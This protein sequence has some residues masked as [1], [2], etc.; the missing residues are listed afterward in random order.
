MVVGFQVGG[1]TKYSLVGVRIVASHPDFI[2]VITT[3]KRNLNLNPDDPKSPVIVE[4]N[5]SEQIQ[6]SILEKVEQA[7]TPQVTTGGR[8]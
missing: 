6:R 7:L 2:T 3:N 4:P 1:T 8:P 5:H